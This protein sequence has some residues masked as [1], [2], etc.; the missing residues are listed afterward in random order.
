MEALRPGDRIDNFTIAAE[1]HQGAMAR[2][3]RA[4]DHL[5]G[6]DYALKIPFD[7][8]LET[9]L[10]YYHFQNEERLAAELIHPHICLLYTSDAADDASSV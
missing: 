6:R 1:L 8:I 3:Y 9:P 7:N 4:R 2:I 10:I 5:S